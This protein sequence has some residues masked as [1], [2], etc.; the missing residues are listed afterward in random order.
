MML[1]FIFL[2]VTELDMHDEVRAILAVSG[3]LAMQ[4]GP[5]NANSDERLST[6]K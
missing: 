4:T 1:C 2:S 6:K 5:L 3:R